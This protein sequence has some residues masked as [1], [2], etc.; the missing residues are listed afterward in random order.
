MLTEQAAQSKGYFKNIKGVGAPIK[1]D[2]SEH[3]PLLDL[4]E[5]HMN[6]IIKR[7]GALPPWI[8]LQ[9]NLNASHNAFRTLLLE[10]YTK[11]IVRSIL[12]TN[13]MSLL[14]SYEQLP[15]RDEAFEAREHK[16]H[17]ESVRQ[18][19]DTLRKMNAQAPLPSRRGL[20]MLEH[21]LERV[22]GEPLRQNVWNEL[23]KRVRDIK[24]LEANG[25]PQRNSAFLAR[26]ENGAMSRL[27]RGM[28]GVLNNTG[29]SGGGH[30]IGPGGTMTGNGH[31][32][33][34]GGGKGLLV[35]VGLG[36]G[37]MVY[38]RKPTLTE[39][40]LRSEN[41]IP[42][43]PEE[44]EER[45]EGF[46]VL[47]PSEPSVGILDLFKEYILEPFLTLV[48]FI[49][50]ALLFGP[51]II[52]APMI[53]V[54]SQPRRK[55]GKPVAEVE[56]NW[57]AVWWYGFL[58]KQMERAGPS[59][60]KLGQWAASRTDLF[61]AALCAKMSK[62][63]SGNKP[64]PFRY[65]KK[66]LQRAFHLPFDEIFE[67]FEEKPIGCGAIAQVYRARLR[68]EILTQ[69]S[70]EAAQLADELAHQADGDRRI[71][72]S[73]AIKVLHPRV[74][75]LVRRDIR[76]MSIFANIIN[77]L[78]E[79]EW[80][81]LPD[82][83]MAFSDMMTQQLDLRV[84][85][86]N[87]DR[88]RENFKDRPRTVTFPRPIRLGPNQVAANKEV[89]IEEYEDALPLK[90]FLRNG[91][92]PYD[93]KIANLGLD[94]FLEMLLLDNWTHGD[95][96]P[97]NIMVRLVR[98][99]TYHII[100]PW[101]HRL[102]SGDNPG[103][104]KDQLST[105]PTESISETETVH[106]LRAVA[107]QPEIWL[108]ELE[109]LYDAG[110]VPQLVFIDAGLVTSLD[111]NNRRNFLDLFQAVAEFDGYRAGKLM[112]ERCRRP[113]LAI[114]E[115]TFALKIQHLVLSVKSK[116]FSLAKIKISD[117][118]N[119][120]LLAVRQHHVKLEGDFVNTVIS[121]LLLEGIGRQLDPNMDLFKSALPILRQLGR[122]MGTKDI[123]SV[124]TGNLFAMAKLWIWAEAR[125]VV[126][127]SSKIDEWIKYDWLSPDI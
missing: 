18:I 57:G 33:D 23:Q 35:F 80:L 120:V 32:G 121:I 84:E 11:H 53:F 95:L 66:V 42:V 127:E 61:P 72:T 101:L 107:E 114:D 90:Y 88:F 78:P 36:L 87:L 54:G 25:P 43:R 92:G 71:V 70:A 106:K 3:N 37:V 126:G 12:S 44:E 75:K 52:T 45:P 58:V 55:P 28:A 97:G 110:F 39:S 73:V 117:I 81:S 15:D 123:A 6:R 60:I 112:V 8:E 113:D 65:T 82:E 38:F 86:T 74:E 31:G 1:R 118:L 103:K 115:E 124:G 9:N 77:A 24:D 89:L 17:E 119:D 102:R 59:F 99:E 27:G 68:P 79:M 67:A 26:L 83:V 49:H 40:P 64:H 93:E 116:T 62:L 47:S 108:D 76:I 7:Q 4:T 125:S 98:P 105:L 91:G 2:P 14:P 46:V 34:A 122:Q 100:G 13:P 94:A 16:F 30:A 85:A 29:G 109:V 22:R 56:D 50:L 48:R 19:N 69:S 63:H 20:V 111:A 5:V 10:S 21:E 104:D 96:H 41:L 51:V